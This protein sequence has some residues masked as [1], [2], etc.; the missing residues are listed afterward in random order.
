MDQA[1]ILAQVQK[2]EITIEQA[3]ALLSAPKPRGVILEVSPKGAVKFKGIRA[4]FP[5]VLYPNELDIILGMA[6]KIGEFV[7]ANKSK[8]SFKKGDIAEVAPETS[9]E[10][11]AA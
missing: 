1:T 11:N 5:I 3:T 8:L 7:E 4:R 2:G 9:A 10:E 6:D